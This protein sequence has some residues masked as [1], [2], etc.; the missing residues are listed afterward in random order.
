MGG[1]LNPVTAR[2]RLQD[3]R[4]GDPHLT[5]RVPSP[6]SS[7]ESRIMSI[8]DDTVDTVDAVTSRVRRVERCT[9][10]PLCPF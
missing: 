8:L 7:P 2:E 4:D 6:R 3:P 9:V 1:L 10:V 5:N